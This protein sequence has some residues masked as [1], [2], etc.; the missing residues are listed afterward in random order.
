[1]SAGAQTDLKALRILLVE[2]DELVRDFVN[3]ALITNVEA[4]NQVEDIR[5]IDFAWIS[6]KNFNFI[7]C[8]YNLPYKGNGVDLL[9]MLQDQ[10]GR[11]MPSLI[12]SGSS[13][14]IL[15]VDH[16]NIQFLPKPF[17]VSQLHLAIRNSLNRPQA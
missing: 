10:L 11:K 3:A 12:I 8:D 15:P 5:A 14:V 6:A 9:I 1:L 17:N 16:P 13:A 4:I 2:D 7:I